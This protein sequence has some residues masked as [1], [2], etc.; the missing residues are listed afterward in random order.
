MGLFGSTLPPI[1]VGEADNH[2]LLVL[3]MSG[4]SHTADQ[5]DDLLYEL[6][7]ARVVDDRL[8]P[9]DVVRMGS[10]VTFTA[11]GG[12]AQTLRLAY[13]HEA[14]GDGISIFSPVGTALLGLRAGQSMQWTARDAKVHEVKVHVVGN[15]RLSD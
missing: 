4:T 11:D 12:S 13:P 2:D 7:R 8:V 15:R 9:A 10:T 3:A 1:L 14:G 5:A 6:G